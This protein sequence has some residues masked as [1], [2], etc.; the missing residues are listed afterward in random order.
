VPGTIRP[1]NGGREKTAGDQDGGTMILR[2]I[3]LA[4][5]E[6]GVMDFASLRNR[7]MVFAT[8]RPILPMC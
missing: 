6:L 3:G 2:S 8:A 5:L 4:N 7:V 1:G